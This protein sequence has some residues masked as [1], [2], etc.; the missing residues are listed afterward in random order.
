MLP[1]T[2]VAV[3]V[4]EPLSTAVTRPEASTV[5]TAVLLLAQVPVPGVDANVTEL[6]IQS[7]LVVGVKVVG[8]AFT[9]IW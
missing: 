5:A 8:V 2:L 9:V 4:A 6:P 7:A 1:S 3:M